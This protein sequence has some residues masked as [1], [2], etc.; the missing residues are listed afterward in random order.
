MVGAFTTKK[1]AFHLLFTAV[2]CLGISGC[3][4]DDDEVS[5]ESSSEV[6]TTD[7]RLKIGGIFPLTG[8][9]AEFGKSAE[10][11]AN[12]AIKDL[13]E[14]GFNVEMMST[15]S[16]SNPTEGVTAASQLVSE[17]NAPVILTSS[18]GVTIPVAEQVTLPNHTL[19]I[20]FAAGT[21]FLTTL[22]ADQ[23]QDLLFRTIP[24]DVAQG[25]V[26]AKT[27]Y[28]QGYQKVAVLYVDDAYGQGLSQAFKEH[29]ENWGGQV[30]ATVP[31][32]TEVKTSYLD[33][34]NQTNGAESL[35]IIS[36]PEHIIVFAQEALAGNL[37]KDYHFVMAKQTNTVNE[38]LDVS[39]FQNTCITSPALVPT[40][41]L[42]KFNQRYQAEYGEVSKPIA[43]NAYD[44][45]VSATL[46]AYAA[47]T[48]SEEVNSTNI[49]NHL[50]GIAGPPGEQIEPQIDELKRAKALLQ[51]SKP[52]NYN[53]SY[54]NVDF[55]ENGDVLAP[56]DVVCFKDG[57]MA[58]Q[59]TVMPNNFEVVG[60]AGMFF[61]GREELVRSEETPLG[62]LVADVMLTSAKA[63]DNAVAAFINGGS[64]RN[65]IAEGEVTYSELLMVL[66]FGNT[67]VVLEIT[68]HELVAALDNGF[69][70]ADGEAT[71]AFLS[72]AGMQVE[73]CQ[74]TPCSNALHEA[75]VVTSLTIEGEA[76][77]MDKTYRI[78]THDFLTGGGDN[79][80]ML[81]EACKRGDYCQDTGKLLVDVLA[82]E[83]QNNSPV[84][85]EVEGRI[86]TP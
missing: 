74:T 30:V 8:V 83:F 50:R 62:N 2:L 25:I 6:T 53:G 79:F 3:N 66:P 65:S 51:A 4:D 37:F 34:L 1:R 43:G 41:S 23:E 52:I 38:A 84:T 55:D 76:V 20:S 63:S 15:D 49:R 48:A 71:G 17:K 60:Q 24:S 28:E 21:P 42:V 59:E 11:G 10:E 16:A 47:Q 46:A 32:S 70:Q 39:V 72:I 18:S 45:V 75:A 12:L 81:E 35:V 78:A 85:R 33:E 58:L 19:Q 31:H 57:E 80:T 69:S 29:F 82:E 7:T 14:A 44:A 36:F 73:Y 86:S 61:D 67:L 56:V 64:L 68:G 22:A 54:S 5:S 27:L 13:T 77:D 40:D 26:L 9:L